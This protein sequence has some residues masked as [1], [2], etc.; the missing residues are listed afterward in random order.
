VADHIGK[1]LASEDPQQLQQLARM[2]ARSS[3]Y[4]DTLRAMSAAATK[5]AAARGGQLA[6]PLG[7]MVG[8]VAEP[9]ER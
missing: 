6:D 2:A 7:G 8:A 9:N 1:M 5:A 3:S 4:M